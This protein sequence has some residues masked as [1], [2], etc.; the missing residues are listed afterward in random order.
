M[1]A[2][3]HA[4]GHAVELFESVRAFLRDH[5]ATRA[6]C[7]V[8]DLALAD[9][10]LLAQEAPTLPRIGLASGDLRTAVAAMK[11]GALDVLDEL[12]GALLLAAVEAG[13]ARDHA[14]RRSV[15]ERMQREA[16]LATLTTREREVVERVARGLLNKQIAAELAI[17]EATVRVHRAR[18]MDKLGVD[19]VIGLVHALLEA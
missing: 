10:A 9:H 15:A 7:V 1:H 3:L 13:L 16:R 11:A 19:S 6:G 17:S 2:C 18:G 8:V 12:D 14:R 5:A 4:A